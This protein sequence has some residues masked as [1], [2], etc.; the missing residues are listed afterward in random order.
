MKYTPAGASSGA[1]SDWPGRG[2]GLPATG[3]R[4]VGRIGRRLGALVIDWGIAL[5]I[6]A[7]LFDYDPLGNLGAFAVLQIVSIATFAGSVGHLCLGLRGVP[8]SGGWIG[9]LRPAARTV[10]L[11]LVIP[12]VI[13]DSD[14]RGFHDRLAGTVLVRR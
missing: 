1:E 6:S 12:A 4:S 3:P 5:L 14:Q 9:V 8:L 11:C 7:V 13:F 2:L 10:L